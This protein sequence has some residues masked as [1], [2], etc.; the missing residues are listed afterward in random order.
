MSTTIQPLF[1]SILAYLIGCSVI[2]SSVHAKDL[3]SHQAD[4]NRA[5]ATVRVHADDVSAKAIGELHNHVDKASVKAFAKTVGEQTA[6]GNER[7]LRS[8]RARYARSFATRVME[9]SLM[10]RLVYARAL[11]S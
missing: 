6:V 5:A 9:A 7:Y 10:F 1:I 3:A 11:A 2:L 4:F 8:G